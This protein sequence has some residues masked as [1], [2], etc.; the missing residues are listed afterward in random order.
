MEE[1]DVER[2][3]EFEAAPSSSSLE[4]ERELPLLRNEENVSCKQALRAAKEQCLQIRSFGLFLKF[5]YNHRQ[6]IFVIALV[7]GMFALLGSGLLFY[8]EPLELA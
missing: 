3:V 4:S 2:S 6:M 7:V 1:S 5:V 8:Y